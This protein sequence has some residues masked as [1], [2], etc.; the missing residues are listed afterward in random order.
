MSRWTPVIW[1]PFSFFFLFTVYWYI[2]SPYI[3][4]PCPPPPSPPYTA[5]EW[6]SDQWCWR[7]R[8][9]CR[10][11]RPSVVHLSPH[12]QSLFNT[13]T[14]IVLLWSKRATTI[15]HFLPQCLPRTRFIRQLLNNMQRI[16]TDLLCRGILTVFTCRKNVCKAETSTSMLF[17]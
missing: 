13:H 11:A 1:C 10:Q 17:S 3:S 15:P 16:R 14:S 2:Y 8:W 5:R 6:E 4:T 12:P 7:E 9:S